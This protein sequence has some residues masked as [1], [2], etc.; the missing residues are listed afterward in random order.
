M[1]RYDKLPTDIGHLYY[2][3]DNTIMFDSSNV[4]ISQIRLDGLVT[5]QPQIIASVP[6]PTTEYDGNIL[7]L[8]SIKAGKSIYSSVNQTM[9]Y[10]VEYSL[11][12]QKILIAQQIDVALLLDITAH[13]N[14]SAG[15]TGSIQVERRIIDLDLVVTNNVELLAYKIAVENIAV[16]SSTND[17]TFDRTSA[18]KAVNF[19]IQQQNNTFR[20]YN[21]VHRPEHGTDKVV[22]ASNA[23]IYQLMSDHRLVKID[24]LTNKTL[25]LTRFPELSVKNYV[26][27]QMIDSTIFI[28]QKT[29]L[30]LYNIDTNTSRELSLEYEDFQIAGN[31][32]VT[33]SLELSPITS[34]FEVEMPDEQSV[35]SNP[36]ISVNYPL[37]FLVAV[38][39]LTIMYRVKNQLRSP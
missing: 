6:P 27:M 28:P 23:T 29:G 5:P 21:N 17:R 39:L 33:R 37:S 31:F 18:D 11:T 35:Q 34:Q 14:L 16:H 8:Q 22:F 2:S 20:L 24:Y 12:D 26:K 7:Q 36:R 13:L 3:D 4:T 19:L 10:R 25:E 32:L 1:R 15:S 38:L 30:L 9:L